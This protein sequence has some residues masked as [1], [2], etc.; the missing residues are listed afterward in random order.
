M[1]LT[2]KQRFME[3][4]LPRSFEGLTKQVKQQEQ[5]IYLLSHMAICESKTCGI[6]TAALVSG[7]QYIQER[8]DRE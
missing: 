3:W 6:R 8:A 1:Y 4:L 2:K 7:E 5:R